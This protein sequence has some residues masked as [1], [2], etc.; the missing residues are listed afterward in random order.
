MKGGSIIIWLIVSI[1]IISV[2]SV[3]IYVSLQPSLKPKHPY[4]SNNNVVTN[5]GNSTL[6]LAFPPCFELSSDAKHVYAIFKSRGYDKK[7][8]KL[9]DTYSL[10]LCQ[11]K[12]FKRN[13]DTNTLDQRLSTLSSWNA[14]QFN[15]DAIAI[16]NSVTKVTNNKIGQ[17]LVQITDICEKQVRDLSDDNNVMREDKTQIIGF[18]SQFYRNHFDAINKSC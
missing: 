11:Q 16:V 3:I 15:K 9:L 1:I 12:D 17:F 10:A 18:N 4:D 13:C 6:N 14:N 7:Y 2:L 5:T 8:S